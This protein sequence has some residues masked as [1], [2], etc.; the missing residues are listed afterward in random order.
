MENTSVLIWLYFRQ[1]IIITDREFPIPSVGLNCFCLFPSMLAWL[2]AFSAKVKFFLQMGCWLEGGARRY[3]EIRKD[4]HS[5][6]T[7]FANTA[8]STLSIKRQGSLAKSLH[9]RR[10]SRLWQT[11]LKHL[12]GSLW[13]KKMKLALQLT[14]AIGLL[15]KSTADLVVWS[16]KPKECS[17]TTRESTSLPFIERQTF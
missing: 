4:K 9:R 1:R 2:C 6:V 11:P 7:A 5:W 15:G 3:W 8:E 13:R 16:G 12:S 10:E 14:L 17:G